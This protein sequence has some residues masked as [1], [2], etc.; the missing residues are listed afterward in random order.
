MLALTMGEP[1]GV[2]GEI[3]LGA[4]KALR[5][6]GPAFLLIDDPERVR[7]LAARHAPDVA[8]EAVAAPAAAVDV[9]P[10]ALPVLP[11]GRRVHAQPG[12]ADPANADAVLEAIRTAVRLAEA[13]AVGGIV[14]NPIHKAVLL[15]AGFA[16]PGHTEF[17]AELSGAQRTVMLLAGP[18]S[19]PSPR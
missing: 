12:V 7:A 5:R 19:V 3:T 9:F 13:G 10:H 6:S 18:G 15:Q 1:A 17:L 16:H 4:W 14:T 8:V 2:G 11:L